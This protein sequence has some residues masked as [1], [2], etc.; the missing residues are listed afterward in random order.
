MIKGF[1]RF[2]IAFF[3]LVLFLGTKGIELHA[4]SHA[5]DGDEVTC[6]WCEHALVIQILPLG[7]APEFILDLVPPVFAAEQNLAVYLSNPQSASAW[8]PFFGRP[9]PSV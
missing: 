7:P 8:E 5:Q 2:F 6:E 1:W 9:P 4:L 3:L